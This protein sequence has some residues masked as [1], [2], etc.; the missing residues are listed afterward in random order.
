[1]TGSFIQALVPSGAGGLVNPEGMVFHDGALYVA[2]QGTS[3]ILQYSASTGQFLGSFVPAGA[4]GLSLPSGLAFGPDGNLYVASQA[5]DSILGFDGNTGAFLGTSV[6]GGT[7]GLSAPADLLF[8]PNG[9]LLVASGSGEVLSY[10]SAGGFLGALVSAG[11]GGLNLPISLLVSVPESGSLTL[12][13]IGLVIAIAARGSSAR[14]PG[15]SRQS[16][17]ETRHRFEAP[18]YPLRAGW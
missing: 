13:L 12:S 15:R 16:Q 11:S 1:M 9:D 6:A 4:G 3:E 17:P 7:G 2:S 10:D 14:P 5:S 18:K 8:E